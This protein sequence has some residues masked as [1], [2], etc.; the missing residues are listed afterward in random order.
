MWW[1][2]YRLA[3]SAA[4]KASGSGRSSTF[5]HS[6]RSARYLRAGDTLLVWK[7]GHLGRSMSHLIET[8]GEVAVRG[9]GLSTV[10]L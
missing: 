2:A 10:R 4:R 8:V 3:H 5:P 6:R 9:I 7:L 1:R